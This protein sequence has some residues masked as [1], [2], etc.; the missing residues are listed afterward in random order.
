[1]MLE[2]SE[3]IEIYRKKN[4]ENWGFQISS[5]R[6]FESIQFL[7]NKQKLK[8]NLRILFSHSEQTE[9]HQ[10]NLLIKIYMK[11]PSPGKFGPA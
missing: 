2:M 6:K 5:P 3:Q 9:M 1:M 7:Q 4:W 10:S 8:T 11:I